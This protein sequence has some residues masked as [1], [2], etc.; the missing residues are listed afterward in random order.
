[1]ETEDPRHVYRALGLSLKH[2]VA[3]ANAAVKSHPLVQ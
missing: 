1:M 3:E 2:P